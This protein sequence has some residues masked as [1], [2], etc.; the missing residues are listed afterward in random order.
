MTLSS[1]YLFTI[2]WFPFVLLYF[3][4][5]FACFFF[6]S[7]LNIFSVTFIVFGFWKYCTRYAG[8]KKEVIQY[9]WRT[10]IGEKTNK[11]HISVKMC[12]CFSRPFDIFDV[13]FHFDIKKIYVYMVIENQIV[14]VTRSFNF[15][16]FETKCLLSTKRWNLID[17]QI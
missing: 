5:W 1:Q 2:S 9:Y 16:E 3:R 12:V 13:I 7:E 15:D 17:F 14:V 10:K 11:S 8:K 4:V 6:S